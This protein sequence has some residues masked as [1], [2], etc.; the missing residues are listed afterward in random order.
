MRPSQACTLVCLWTRS[1]H[2]GAGHL[3]TSWARDSRQ[4]SLC[5][6]SENAGRTA[7]AIHALAAVTGMLAFRRSSVSSGVQTVCP[8]KRQVVSGRPSSRLAF[9]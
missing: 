2:G 8:D 5:G 3:I 1:R 4:S 6:H 9:P 7:E